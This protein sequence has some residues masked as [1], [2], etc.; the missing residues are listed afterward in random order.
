MRFSLFERA[1]IGARATKKEE[2]GR[3]LSALSSQYP[4]GQK[5]KTAQNNNK[6]EEKLVNLF[7]N[8]QAM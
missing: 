3:F 2:G 6:K 8:I 1:E 4:R 7:A 5:A